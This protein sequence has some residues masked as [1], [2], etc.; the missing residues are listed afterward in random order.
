MEVTTIPAECVTELTTLFKDTI[1]TELILHIW[2][3]HVPVQLAN[4]NSNDPN[5]LLRFFSSTPSY[6]ATILD[7]LL[8]YFAKQPGTRVP[9][10]IN[11]KLGLPHYHQVYI[12]RCSFVRKII[13]N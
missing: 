9:E 13:W 2:R 8:K 11:I 12:H 5:V 4:L 1:L 7:I 10:Q 3:S 6:A